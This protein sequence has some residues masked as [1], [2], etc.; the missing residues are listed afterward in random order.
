MQ[1]VALWK[2]LQ[3]INNVLYLRQSQQKTKDTEN[4]DNRYGVK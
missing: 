2:L 1:A 4:L 3:M